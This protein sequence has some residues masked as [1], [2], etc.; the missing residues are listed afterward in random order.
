[1]GAIGSAVPAILHLVTGN[2]LFRHQLPR[3]SLSMPAS[4]TP[5]PPLYSLTIPTLKG[6]DIERELTKVLL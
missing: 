1:V 4:E 6:I 2:A 5:S 3:F